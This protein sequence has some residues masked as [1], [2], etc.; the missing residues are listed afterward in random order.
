M[1]TLLAWNNNLSGNGESHPFDLIYL[2]SCFLP[3]PSGFQLRLPDGVWSS[4]SP[5]SSLS[6]SLWFC[7]ASLKAARNIL[8]TCSIDHQCT[9]RVTLAN[10]LPGNF[11]ANC[12]LSSVNLRSLQS[13]QVLF[14]HRPV[15]DLTCH[16][17]KTNPDS[18]AH[19]LC[20]RLQSLQA[21]KRQSVPPPFACLVFESGM[22]QYGRLLVPALLP[23]RR[24]LA[25]Y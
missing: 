24:Q 7:F 12:N 21:P 3:L 8:Q 9:P 6:T 4:V 10:T 15:T 23:I 19:N 16:S 14:H 1:P 22:M 11:I 20:K 18:S 25:L 17:V 2:A 5:E 13:V